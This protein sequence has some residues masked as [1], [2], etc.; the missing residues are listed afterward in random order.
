MNSIKRK[1]AILSRAQRTLNVLESYYDL[2][3]DEGWMSKLSGFQKRSEFENLLGIYIN[4]K[5]TLENTVVFSDACIYVFREKKWECIL[6]GDIK[7]AILPDSKN[8]I[9]GFELSKKDG[10]MFWIPITGSKNDHFFDAFE[11][12]RFIDRIL[13]IEKHPTT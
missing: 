12:I 6:F 3:K 2:T 9:T 7:W 11:V 1:S 8:K 13:E 10:S 4:D 5:I